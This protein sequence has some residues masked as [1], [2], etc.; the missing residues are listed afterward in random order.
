MSSTALTCPFCSFEFNET[1]ALQFLD[2]YFSK[3]SA[4][5]NGYKSITIRQAHS[6]RSYPIHSLI[7]SLRFYRVNHYNWLSRLVFEFS[8]TRS[9]LLHNS[10]NLINALMT[11]DD[12][13]KDIDKDE[14]WAALIL[15]HFLSVNVE[16]DDETK[17]SVDRAVVWL[18]KH[19][20][21]LQEI[22]NLFVKPAIFSHMNHPLILYPSLS[23]VWYK[24]ESAE[25]AHTRSNE[26]H[27][28]YPV[29]TDNSILDE[30][31]EHLKSIRQKISD[32]E[33]SP[34]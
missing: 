1:K 27:S 31:E 16:I 32:E 9:F 34:L 13:P 18:W 28:Q 4:T 29:D 23:D 5:F 30:L 24:Q 6:D 10:I 26:F 7:A 33:D 15:F 12:D 25:L 19:A 21:N 8:Q 11:R 20:D 22:E 2:R 3:E 17:S 14:Y